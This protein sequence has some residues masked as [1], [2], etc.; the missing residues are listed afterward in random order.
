MRLTKLFLIC[1]SLA[2]VISMGIENADYFILSKQS[3]YC[4]EIKNNSEKGLL[5]Q[6]ECK[7][8]SSQKFEIKKNSD[9]SILIK[10]IAIANDSHLNDAQIYNSNLADEFK[11]EKK[12]NYFKIKSKKSKKYIT[13][14]IHTNEVV[15]YNGHKTDAQLWRFSKYLPRPDS[16]LPK[17]CKQILEDGESF[18]NGFYEIDPDN[19]GEEI[20]VYCD[21]NNG[22]WTLVA[23]LAY[24]PS[25]KILTSQAIGEKVDLT[26]KVAKLSDEKINSLVNNSN[27][28]N[29]YKLIITTSSKNHTRYFKNT[30]VFKGDSV[31]SGNC[32]GAA[33]NE[34]SNI[35]Y[36]S[37]LYIGYGLIA[38]FR[39]NNE[40]KILYWHAANISNALG[41]IDS[42]Y[43]ENVGKLYIK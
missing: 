13:S 9:N 31:A 10:S 2:P 21:M 32:V 19:S 28:L 23:S 37:S 34:N 12:G 7:D 39:G 6:N 35:Y 24:D 29:S 1:L 14:K 17:S 33:I 22:G 38:N 20:E 8:I 3:G 36:G 27:L 18:G 41:D 30:C 15:Q 25:N 43:K 4:L 40:N 26:R 42:T 16:S 5:L 11:L